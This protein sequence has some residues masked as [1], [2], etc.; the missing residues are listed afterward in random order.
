VGVWQ[1]VFRQPRAQPSPGV[2]NPDSR[3]QP[4]DVQW[5]RA[6]RRVVRRRTR[7]SRTSW[8]R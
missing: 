4:V 7:R 5:C 1:D 3:V 6:A 8:D 2:G